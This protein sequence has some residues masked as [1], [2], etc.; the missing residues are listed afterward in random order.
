MSS[1]VAPGNDWIE[2]DE[3]ADTIDGGEGTDRITYWYEGVNINLQDQVVS[4]GDAK[5]IRSRAS[6]R[7]L[8]QNN[9]D[10]IVGSDADNGCNFVAERAMI[11]SLVWPATIA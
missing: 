8:V 5:E 9:D 3:G 11:R 6:R 10:I 1:S 7:R 2:A 4:G